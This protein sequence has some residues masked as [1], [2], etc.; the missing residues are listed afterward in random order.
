MVQE[1]VDEGVTMVNCWFHSRS[2]SLLVIFD[3]VHTI[4]SAEVATPF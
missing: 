4:D 1:A 3:N 2:G